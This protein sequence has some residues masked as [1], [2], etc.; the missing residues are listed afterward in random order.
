MGGRA[1]AGQQAREHDGADEREREVVG[2]KTGTG[3]RELDSKM[4]KVRVARADGVIVP[5][6]DS[7]HKFIVR[8]D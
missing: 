2:Q 7:L 5:V 1:A 4:A 3:H 8:I 6:G